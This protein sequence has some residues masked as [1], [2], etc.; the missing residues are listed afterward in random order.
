MNAS[1]R[2][3]RLEKMQK[4]YHKIG[5]EPISATLGSF[6]YDITHNRHLTQSEMQWLNA[7]YR[8]MVDAI[9]LERA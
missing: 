9:E 3:D 8:D 6:I 4:Y 1:Q 5:K 2:L 7:R